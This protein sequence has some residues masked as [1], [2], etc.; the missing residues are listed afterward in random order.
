MIGKVIAYGD[1]REQA[2]A[3]M[4]VALSEMVV[5]G[6]KTNIPLHQE[7]LLDDKFL[8][9][10]TS[11]HYLEERLAKRKQAAL[12]RAAPMPL[13]SRC[14]SMRPPRRPRPGPTRCSTPARSSVDVADAACRHRRRDA[15]ATASPARPRRDAVAGLPA[16][17]AVRGGRRRRSQRSPRRRARSALAPPAYDAGSRRRTGLGARDAG[18]VR[19]DPHRRPPLDR[20]VVVR[21]GRSRRRSISTLDPG[22][23]FGTGSASD[24]AAVPATGSRANLAPRRSRCSTTAA[25]RAFS[26]SPPRSSARRRLPASTSTRRRSKRAAPMPRATASA[27]AFALPDALAPGDV[28]RRRRQHPG[29]SAAPARAGARRARPATAARSCCRA[30]S[31]TQAAAVRGGVSRDGLNSAHGGPTTDG[32]R[33]RVGG[34]DGE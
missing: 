16:D 34:H 18:A 17:R 13:L 12:G 31:T 28:R 19:A 20:A 3:R 2:I 24:D 11:I 27:R 21:A 22:L 32:W 10:G 6:I 4:R 23:A 5:E 7:L 14:A 15:A 8:R 1:T 9:G 25:A 30:Y 33:W 26:R 29:Q